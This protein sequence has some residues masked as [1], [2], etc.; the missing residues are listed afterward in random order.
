[1]SDNYRTQN[2][3]ANATASGYARIHVGNYIENTVNHIY[4]EPRRNQCLA[5][6]RLTDPRDEKIRIEDT[7]GGLIREAYQWILDHENFQRWR[8]DNKSRLL[9]IKG[10]P[11]KGKTMLLCGIIGEL[12]KPQTRP[13]LLS[14][15]LC[16]ETD[17]RLNHASA[18]LRGLI[19]CLIIQQPPLIEH[20]EK[21]YEHVGKQLFEGEDAF[22]K[23]SRVLASMLSD[24][25]AKRCYL[26]VDALDECLHD[27]QQLLRLI[28]ESALNYPAKW[29]VSSRNRLDIEQV[30][31]LDDSRTRVSLELN[32]Q[33]VAQALNTFIDRKLAT[34]PILRNDSS[35]RRNVQRA[36]QSKATGNFLWVDM[37]IRELRAV[38]PSRMLDTLTKMPPGLVP[39]YDMMMAKVREQPQE[40]VQR[41]IQM[42]SVSTIA[43]R[44][45]TLYELGSL[46]LSKAHTNTTH[47]GDVKWYIEKCGAFLTIAQDG[48]V[49]LL[50]QS[51]KDYFANSPDTTLGSSPAAL[52]HDMALK[53]IEEMQRTFR[54]DVYNLEHEGAPVPTYSPNPDPL[55]SVPYHCINWVNHLVDSMSNPEDFA[56][57]GV[58]DQFLR[59][60]FLHWLEALSLLRSLSSGILILSKLSSLVQVSPKTFIY[61]LG[62]DY[63]KSNSKQESSQLVKLIRDMLRFVRYHKD[64]IETSPLQVYS[65]ALIF[66]PM[67]SVVR[68]LFEA[69]APSWISMITEVDA[70][71]NACLQTIE[72]HNS[73]V[74][75]VAFAPDGRHLASAS[76]DE[77]V[78]LWDTA[79]GQCQ[80]T[81]KGHS[82]WV[83]SVAFSP[84]GRQL[85]SASHDKTVKLWDTA[86]GQCQRT[87]EGHDDSVNS[88]TFSPDRHQLASASNDYTVKPW[89]TA[90]GQCQRTLEG[91][92]SWV[93]SVAFSP[94]GRQLASASNND[95][96]KLWDTA[97]GQCQR[98]LEDHCS[99]ENVFMKT[100]HEP[101]PGANNQG[102]ML[103]QQGVWITNNS[104]NILRLPSEYRAASFV[105]D[106]S[107]IAIGC[108]SG[109]V[110]LL[111]VTKGVFF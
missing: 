53:S 15:F 101:A 10:D 8:D 11:G 39:F 20:I 22:Y 72:G 85:A 30:L 93:L 100:T 26:V 28:A 13:R 18:V 89:D 46:S 35:T 96:V 59:S 80:R 48:S 110:L 40:D 58:V 74:L 87:L 109:C 68:Q 57:H 25:V 86:T 62:S 56:N 38:E 94:D 49:Y 95:T 51:V 90:T 75:S 37:V 102:Q 44:P 21:T 98:T 24:P 41:C 17:S 32:E 71:W 67:K 2:T 45:L 69:E 14:F 111:Q 108:Q 99:L 79:T 103:S 82:S 19:Y 54:R 70:D 50:H 107:K 52:H 5:D 4:N 84:D 97:T 29:I 43:Y 92:S 65:S 77:T 36:I 78:K 7:K 91:H 61:S 47:H 1:M 81:L 106:G 16:Q 31:W 64:G 73:W 66:S 12:S 34:L 42:L 3:I 23:L 55:A 63:S 83:R 105:V 76:D 6:L 9:W 33:Y 27:Q 104:Q 88:V 60:N